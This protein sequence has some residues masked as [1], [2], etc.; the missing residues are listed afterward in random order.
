MK[1]VGAALAVALGLATVAFASQST[2][3]THPATFTFPVRAEAQSSFLPESTLVAQAC[4]KV[5][6]KGKACGD[7]CIARDKVCRQPPGCACDG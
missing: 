3:T 6:R 1:L 7:S 5:C 4:C 2:V